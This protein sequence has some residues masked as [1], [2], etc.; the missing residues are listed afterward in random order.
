[1]NAQ[2]E[3]IQHIQSRQILCAEITN[4]GPYDENI[5][6]F[7][8]TTGYSSIEFQKFLKSLDFEYD[9]GYG[10][11]EIYGII[12]YTDNTWSSRGE[13]DG[14]EWWEYNKCPEIPQ[15]L[16][17]IDKVRDKSINKIIQ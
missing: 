5:K 15:H 13:Y 14:S 8:L 3:F 1:M 9:G 10:G 11:Q 16:N 17:R 12:W 6:K 2:H 4:G 7:I